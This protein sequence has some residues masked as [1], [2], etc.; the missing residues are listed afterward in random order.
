VGR[1]ALSMRLDP[2]DVKYSDFRE[3]TYETM[4]KG[5]FDFYVLPGGMAQDIISS[6]LFEENSHSS[7]GTTLFFMMT[8]MARW[9]IEHHLLEQRVIDSMRHYIPQ[10]HRGDF[11]ADIFPE[12]RAEV[13]DDVDFV[14]KALLQRGVAMA[15]PGPVGS[16]DFAEWVNHVC[17]WRNTGAPTDPEPAPEK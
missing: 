8:Q 9:E 12:E 5:E 16:E 6:F 17:S 14:E 13:K 15:G 2:E 4:D 3:D 10:Y 11:D 1:Q 7:E